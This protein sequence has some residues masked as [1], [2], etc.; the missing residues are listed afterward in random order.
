M[1][2]YRVQEFALM[3]GVTART[4]HHYDRVGLLRPLRTS[5]GYRIY[6]DRHLERLEQ[7]IALKFLGLSLKQIQDVLDRNALELVEA[8]RVQRRVLEQRKQQLDRAIAAIGEAEAVIETGKRPDSALLKKIIEVLEMENT[9]EWLMSYYSEDARKAIQERGHTVSKEQQEQAASDWQ[10]LY[11]EVDAAAE[12]DPA[13]PD[14]QSLAARWVKLVE[15][16]TGGN[17]EIL[18]GLKKLYTDR[19]NWPSGFSQ[20][21][22]PYSFENPNANTFICR[23]IEVYRAAKNNK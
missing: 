7:I 17:P 8:L 9:Q 13:S 14:A 15:G 10:Q 18:A 23:A 3:A 5:S 16:F 11:R 12:M 21:M 6:E 20:Q 22:A 2:A 4:L 1:K 19:T